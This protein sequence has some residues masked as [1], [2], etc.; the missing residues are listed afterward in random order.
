[1]QHC[2]R[3][4]IMVHVI[5]SYHNAEFA[6]WC[7]YV[8]EEGEDLIVIFAAGAAVSSHLTHGSNPNYRLVH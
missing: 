2:V 5:C 6:A 3:G 1:M 4:L 8:T 7:Y